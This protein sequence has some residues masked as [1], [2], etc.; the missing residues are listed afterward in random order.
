LARPDALVCPLAAVARPDLLRPF[1]DVVDN[2]P[3]AV[4]LWDADLDAAR[5]AVLDMAGVIPEGHQGLPVLKDADAGKLA[6]HGLRPA[7]AV[8]VR[9][10]SAW[11]LNLVLPA[12]AGLVAR[13]VE[14]LAAAALYKPGAAP[15]A[16]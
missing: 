10:D 4:N 5:R 13:S 11:A 2:R 3:D 8:L 14:Q 7:D 12:W 9:P 6:G 15:S 1:R 16:A